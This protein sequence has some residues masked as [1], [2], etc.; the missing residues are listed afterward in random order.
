MSG[1]VEKLVVVEKFEYMRWKMIQMK[2]L[3]GV[4][5]RVQQKYGDKTKSI[6]IM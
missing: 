2:K 1:K 5:K 3:V 4:D 6:E